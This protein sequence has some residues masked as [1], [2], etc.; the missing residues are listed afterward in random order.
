MSGHFLKVIAVAFL[1]ADGRTRTNYSFSSLSR[2]DNT[3]NIRPRTASTKPTLCEPS[4]GF[5]SDG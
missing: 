3:F 4:A 2:L 1:C 5:S